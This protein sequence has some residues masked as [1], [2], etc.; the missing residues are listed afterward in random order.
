MKEAPMAVEWTITIEGRNAVQGLP[1]W[2]GGRLFAAEGNL[3]RS[4]D[5]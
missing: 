3:L 2:H 4:D 1:S 5:V